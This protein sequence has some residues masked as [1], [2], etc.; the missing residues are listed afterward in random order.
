MVFLT[1]AKHDPRH[2]AKVHFT[3]PRSAKKGHVFRVLIHIDKV[4]DLLFYHFLREELITD[5]RV[6]WR[7]FYWQHGWADGELDEDELHPPE[8]SCCLD[9]QLN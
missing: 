1:L 6:Q 9:R 3:M 2:D 4:E 7:D 5:G 8:D